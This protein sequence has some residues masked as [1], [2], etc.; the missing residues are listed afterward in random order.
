MANFLQRPE[1]NTGKE[2]ILDS[3]GIQSDFLQFIPATVTGVVNS[4]ESVISPNPNEANM[5]TATKNI[6]SEDIN[7]RSSDK[8][9]YKPLLRG[10]TD[11]IAVGD[12]VLVTYIGNNGYYLGPVN[13][14]N[15]PTQNFD[16]TLSRDTAIEGAP[17]TTAENKQ[18]ISNTFPIKTFFTRLGKQFN[19]ELDDPGKSIARIKH[20]ST[21]NDVFSD[22]HTDL[23]LEGR[24][25]NSI[26]LG[27]RNIHPHIFISNGRETDQQTE[28]IL[29]D[30]II[31]LTTAGTLSQHF[32]GALTKLD[33]EEYE[34]KLADESIET[35]INYITDTFQ[36]SLGR[37][38]GLEGEDNPDIDSEMSGYDKSQL[39]I[40][41]DRITIN[42]KKDNMFL[43]SFNHMHLGSGNSMTFSTSNNFLFNA[44]A[45]DA[46]FSINATEIRLGSQT[47]AETEPLIL[48][49]TLIALL[50]RLH[51]ELTSLCSAINSIT[52]PTSQGPSGTPINAAQ[53]SSVSTAI[54]KIQG[55]LKTALS[56]RNR[57]T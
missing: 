46:A 54:G 23:M 1:S 53:I 43:S 36:K 34:F 17:G 56:I 57:T 12:S 49:D 50:D 15:S 21:G 13:T 35:P 32:P 31:S 26:R 16:Q 45:P 18:G 28:S 5:I 27:S 14:N 38:L 24:H 41:S 40:N 47:D 9:K 7:L 30:S 22:I 48:G 44:G 8:T 37:G 2:Y 39:L 4:G 11:S 42:S 55:E 6:F 25:G 29:D 33:D 10:I 20:P 52:V 3:P 19:P 51:S